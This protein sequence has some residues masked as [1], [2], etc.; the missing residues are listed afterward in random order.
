MNDLRSHLRGTDLSAPTTLEEEIKSY[1]SMINNPTR[2]C[3][4]DTLQARIDYLEEMEDEYYSSEEYKQAEP[5]RLAQAR[6]AQAKKSLENYR[7]LPLGYKDSFILYTMASLEEE[8]E[9]LKNL[10]W[11][12]SF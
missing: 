1:L 5:M 7:N 10:I 11:D 9:E 12:M 3:D 4:A 6:L 8:I 2:P